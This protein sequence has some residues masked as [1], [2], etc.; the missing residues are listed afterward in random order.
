VFSVS[1]SNKTN[2]RDKR[3]ITDFLWVRKHLVECWEERAREVHSKVLLQKW[4]IVRHRRSRHRLLWLVE[5]PRGFGNGRPSETWIL[6]QLC[7]QSQ[8][9]SDSTTTERCRREI[10]FHLFSLLSTLTRFPQLRENKIPRLFQITLKYFQAFREVI[11]NSNWKCWLH[12]NSL[13]TYFTMTPLSSF[14]LTGS[15][16]PNTG[17]IPLICLKICLK[18]VIKNRPKFKLIQ[19]THY[20]TCK[21]QLIDKQVAK[22]VTCHKKN[23]LTI[24]QIPGL[25]QV[26]QIPW[27]FQVFQVCG[28]PD[29]SHVKP[30]SQEKLPEWLMHGCYH[31]QNCTDDVRL[32]SRPMSEVL[33]WYVHSCTHR[34]VYTP[35]H[36]VAARSRLR[37]ADHG[38]IVVPCAWSTHFG[39]YSYRMCRHT[40]FSRICEGNS[41][42]V[43]LR[44]SSLSVRTAGDID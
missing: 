19:F 17:S 12:E 4:P 10:C 8:S 2:K 21:N 18:S 6:L 11:D 41:L 7:W 9:K 26:Y 44:A 33:W 43:G 14:F 23:S 30:D 28:N 29:S 35:V 40:N 15:S 16:L 13:L 36:T 20:I 42:N 32:F 39:C 25:L 1:T 22:N 34:Y 24:S 27:Q 31:L 5:T 3:L 38:D 37:S